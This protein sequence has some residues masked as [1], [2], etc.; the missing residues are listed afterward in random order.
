MIK[1]S[2]EY[3]GRFSPFVSSS[4]LASF[5][6]VYNTVVGLGVMVSAGFV[7][8][9]VR[10]CIG[11]LTEFVGNW[12]SWSSR[13]GLSGAGVFGACVWVMGV[14]DGVAGVWVSVSFHQTDNPRGSFTN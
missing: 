6:L 3:R 12:T 10:A 8:V 13:C 9:C 7:L 1:F 11:S 4:G 5:G 14:A 2:L